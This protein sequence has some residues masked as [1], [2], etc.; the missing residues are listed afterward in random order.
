MFA[1]PFGLAPNG[2]NDDGEIL[3]EIVINVPATPTTP[4]DPNFG[5]RP[6]Y[7]PGIPSYY[8]GISDQY[9][10]GNGGGGPI[11][12]KSKEPVFYKPENTS[13]SKE[14]KSG[15]TI[16]DLVDGIKVDNVIIKVTDGYSKIIINADRSV[17]VYYNNPLRFLYYKMKGGQISNSPDK[18]WDNLFNSSK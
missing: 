15:E 3:D 6:S 9:G 12:N 10:G 1:D 2:G 8:T 7:T 11:I 4:Q 18:G 13:E 5:T 17:E 16:D 14:I